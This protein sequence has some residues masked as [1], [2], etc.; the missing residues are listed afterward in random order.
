[1]ARVGGE[2]W[3]H[4]DFMRLWSAQAISAFGSRITREGL[5]LAAARS[6][7]FGDIRCRTDTTSLVCVNYARQSGVYYSD[8][9]ID[10]YGCTRATTPPPGIGTLFEC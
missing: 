7:S 8:A 5:P 2:L 3:K 4:P 6:L 1:L 9:G 10:T